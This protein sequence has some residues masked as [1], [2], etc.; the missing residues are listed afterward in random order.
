[1]LNGSSRY[2]ESIDPATALVLNPFNADAR[3]DAISRALDEAGTSADRDHVERAILTGLRLDPVDARFYS[4][5]GELTLRSDRPARAHEL[6]EQADRISRT[7]RLALQHLIRHAVQE[8]DYATTAER[9]NILIRRW[10][11]QFDALAPAF[12]ALLAQAPAYDA[13]LDDMLAQ[14]PWRGR[15]LSALANDENGLDFAYRLLF[16]LKDGGSQLEPREIGA[17]ADGFVKKKRYNDAYR[18][19]LFA[20]GE[21]E[22]SKS[23]YVHNS[24]FAQSDAPRPFSWLHRN[25]SAAEIRMAAGPGGEG[26]RVRFLNKPAREVTLRQTLVL[27]PG[28][29]VLKVDASAS[30]LK[31]PRDLYW[32]IRCLDPGREI[33]RLSVAEGTYRSQLMSA[34]FDIDACPAQSISLAT[35]LIAE[36]WRYRYVG[37][38][39]S[40]RVA[41]ERVEFGH[42]EG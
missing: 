1:M 28:R 22:G 38:V 14:A 12:P 29:Y 27:A 13:V 19:F 9:M 34:E 17:V 10:P 4:L 23:G 2:L 21:Q 7:E 32:T 16:D 30:G 39:L 20:L 36:S 25:S 26:A 41:V 37:Q 31:V 8:G 11:E 5:L 35:G 6:F 3:T 18:L 24:R 15:L 40:H 33:V 42:V